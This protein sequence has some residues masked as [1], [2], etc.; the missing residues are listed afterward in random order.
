MSKLKAFFGYGLAALG[1]PII[2]ATFMGQSFWS[3]TLVSATGV[4]ISP[5]ITGDE[6]AR[7]VEHGQYQTRLH[8]PVFMALI[9]EQPEGFVQVD[10]A[11]LGSVPAQL[12]E[13][14]DYNADGQP[15]FRVELD[16]QTN[17]AKITPYGAHVIGLGGVYKLKEAWAVRVNVKNTK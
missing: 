8:K 1:L 2:L 6:V 13:D 16:T 10:W 11:P 3:E 14:I 12:A 17:Q 4:R 7:T 15:D 5:W 9:G